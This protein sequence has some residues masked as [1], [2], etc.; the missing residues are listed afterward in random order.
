MDYQYLYNLTGAVTPLETD[1]GLLC[2]SIC[3][4]RDRKNTL[5][6]YLFPGEEIMLP[7]DE[8]WIERE[9]HNPAEYDFPDNWKEPVHFIKCTSP[10]PREKRPL[11][12]RFFPLAPHLLTDGALIL[13][14]ETVRLPYRCPL[15]YKE[16]P[17]RKDFVE[18]VA[19]AWRALLQD[20]RIFRLVEEDSREREISLQSIPPILWFQGARD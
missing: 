15:I 7:P 1:C 10:C 12:C 8:S 16:L 11:S 6:I 9:L 18:V 14:Y 20:P 3:C 19:L 13:T 5:G 4:R 2:S 17:L